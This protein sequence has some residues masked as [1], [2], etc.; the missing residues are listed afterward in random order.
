M[1]AYNKKIGL[2]VVIIFLIP[3]IS[4]GV[5]T[6][7]YGT[8]P[9][10]SEDSLKTA[11]NIHTSAS[12]VSILV[13]SQYADELRELPNTIQAINDSYGTEYYYENL[14]DYTNLNT[15]LPGHDILL[16]PEQEYA[17]YF[18]LETIGNAWAATLT[19]FVIKGGIVILLDHH[20]GS[21]G[22]LRI[23]NASGLMEIYGS[24]SI[25]GLDVYVVKAYDPLAADVSSTFIAPAGSLSFNTTETTSVV[26]DG[27]NPMVVHKVLGNG[28][29]VLLGFDFFDIE[30]NCSTILGNSIRLTLLSN[31]SGGLVISFGSIYLI[32]TLICI[33]SLVGLQKRLKYK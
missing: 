24:T 14:T 31:G 23:Y 18:Q 9:K 10:K 17:S 30:S 29:I 19:T 25:S 33:I 3:L 21:G 11:A 28:H 22:T 4:F 13:Y 15:E 7:F 16:I 32:I 20:W 1:K 27:I 8:S 6:S 26:D 12:N 5:L 2:I